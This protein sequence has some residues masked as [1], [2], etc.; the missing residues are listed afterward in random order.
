ML[1]GETYLGRQLE[2]ELGVVGR[3]TFERFVPLFIQDVVDAIRFQGLDG[4]SIVTPLAL[5]GVGAMTY[6]VRASSESARLKDTYA[7]KY[8]GQR[9][10]DIGPEAQGILR[11]HKPQ[12]ALKEEE[13][14]MERENYSFMARMAEEQRKAAEKVKKKLPRNVQK[15]LDNL[16]VDIKGLS[17]HIASNWYLNDKRYKQYQN[18]TVKILNA[19]LPKMIRSPIW[20]KMD[21]ETRRE[22]MRTLIDE[23]KKV[24][25]NRIIEDANINDME[26]LR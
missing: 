4:A 13:A 18:N 2:P 20:N 9:W 15:E 7:Q 12:L 14:R 1:R 23:A 5:H 26:Q 8:F 25:R 24:A 10:D 16:T 17:R 3:E 6:P 11:E 21:F 19:V 22:I